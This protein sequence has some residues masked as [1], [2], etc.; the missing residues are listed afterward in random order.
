VSFDALKV[1]AAAVLLSPTIPLLFMGEEYAETSPF[2]YFVDHGDAALIDAVRRGRAEEFASFGWAGE[3][4]DPQSPTTF[5]RSRLTRDGTLTERQRAMFAWYRALITLR[6]S[7]PA[8]GA[9]ARRDHTVWTLARER[10]LVILRPGPGQSDALV[11]LGFGAA[12]ARLMLRE[13]TGVW[14]RRLDA[15]DLAFGGARPSFAPASLRI[16]S[17]GASIDLPAYSAMVFLRA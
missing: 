4:P 1:A 7:V 9:A 13:P 8:L 15:N 12:P 16:D 14:T 6:T 5:E 10:A 3:V 17:E 11:I 2:L